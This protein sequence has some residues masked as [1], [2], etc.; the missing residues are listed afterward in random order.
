M[1]SFN[2]IVSICTGA[3]LVRMLLVLKPPDRAQN[4][5]AYIS[6]YFRPLGGTLVALALVSYVQGYAY[7][8]HQIP[9]GEFVPH[10][11][12]PNFL[13]KGVG[14]ENLNGGGFNNAFGLDFKANSFV[15]CFQCLSSS[16]FAA[17]RLFSTIA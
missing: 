7:L 11:C 8:Q 9:N 13:W 5:I 1:Q 12:K 15:S 17:L 4:L 6:L 16:I 2:I 3:D 10:P 14:H